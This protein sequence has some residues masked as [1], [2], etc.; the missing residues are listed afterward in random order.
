MGLCPCSLMEGVWLWESGLYVISKWRLIKKTEGHSDKVS[1]RWGVSA[2]T[3]K[4]SGS[5]ICSSP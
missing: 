2:Q 5:G 1:Q 3:S 4:E